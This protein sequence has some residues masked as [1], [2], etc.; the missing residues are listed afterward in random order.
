[1]NLDK[2]QFRASVR[3]GWQAVDLGYLMASAWW[4]Q[5]FVFGALP[6]VVV[7]IPLFII[8]FDQPYWAAFIIW[9]L[10]PFWERL[11]LYFASRRIFGEDSAPGEIFLQTGSLYKKDAIPWLLWRRFSFQR[12][13]DAPVTVLEE[14]KRKP[15]SSRLDVLHGKYSDVALANQFI[16]F[17]FEWIFSFGIAA[18]LF[19]FI[20]DDFGLEIYDSVDDLNLAGQRVYTLYWFIAMTLVMPFHTMAGFALY[21]NRRIELEAWDI[22]ITF[23][24]LANRKRQSTKSIAGVLATVLL[25]LLLITATPSTS[26]AAIDHDGAS[27]GQLIDEVL[28]GEDFGQEK[29]VRKWRFKNLIEGN[30]DKIPEWLI[31]LIE[32]WEKNVK[33]SSADETPGTAAAWLKIALIA[34]AILLAIYLLYRYRGSLAR[35]KGKQKI[36]SAPE[37]MFGLDVRPESLPDDVPAQAMELWRGGQHRDA[38]GLLYRASL[39]RLI[40]QYAVAFK[41]SHTESECAALVRAQGIDSLSQYFA[42]LT[43]IW[44]HLA[45]GHESPEKGTMQELCDG[46]T[47]EMSG[48]I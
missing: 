2:L 39:S 42:G 9:W 20:P 23:R 44:C 15:R 48:A 27:A 35:R 40:E 45:Y 29:T 18:L 16:S 11:P 46:W 12:A 47:Q 28:K 4:R 30:E 32:W 10:K 43:R 24:N 8:L 3:S 31:A 33:F 7:F 26:Y 17:C 14:L 1:M 6:S 38:L 37:L 21:L 5:L 34:L 19:F 13:F 22:E 25:A 36:D 41:S